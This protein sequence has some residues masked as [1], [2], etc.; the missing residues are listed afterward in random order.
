MHAQ[1]CMSAE[2]LY[3]FIYTRKKLILIVRTYVAGICKILLYTVHCDAI[4]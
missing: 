4:V 3:S 1:K 2:E